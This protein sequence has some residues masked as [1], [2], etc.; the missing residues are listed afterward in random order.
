[1]QRDT[2]NVHWVVRMNRRN[3]TWCG[4]LLFGTM[5]SHLVTKETGA[6]TWVLLVAQYFAYPQLVYLYARRA[7]RPMRAEMNNLLL[8]GFCFGV[9]AAVL[10]FPIWITFIFL[11]TVTVNMTVF[12]G[13]PGFVQAIAA[14]TA[15][16]LVAIVAGG[17][18]FS[19]ETG[20]PATI[21][22]ILTISIY[23]L[24]VADSAYHR[25]VSLHEAR[26][27]IRANEQ[28]LMHKLEQISALEAQLREQANRDPLTGLFNRRFFD[29]TL[30]REIARCK[31]DGHSLSV[32]MI[33]V[34]HFKKIND[35]YGH[36]AGDEVLRLLGSI[37]GEGVRASDVVC[38]FGGEEFLVLLPSMGTQAAQERAEQ[39]R[40]AFS[41]TSVLL[42]R[43]KIGATFSAGIATYPDNCPQPEALVE[44]ADASLYC[45]K[46][47]GRNRIVVSGDNVAVPT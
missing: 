43:D 10:G 35:T 46:K 5:V 27:Q 3:R 13:K 38:R 14:M 11:V 9:W 28:A 42:S 6:L 30:E 24:V 1:M 8:D 4:L 22:S 20:W 37:L 31:R 41:T 26:E 47:E 16:A 7:S 32:V 44:C 34:D 25:A 29:A 45:A 33:D 39:W 17:F 15:G 36:Q 40:I 18:H 12:R 19:P 21:L 23:V 2:K